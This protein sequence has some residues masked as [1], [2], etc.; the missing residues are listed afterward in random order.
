MWYVVP[1]T[2][3]AAPIIQQWGLPGDVPVPA[4]FSTA[5][6]PTDFAVWRPS[7]GTW[8]ILPNSGLN[9]SVPWGVS[10]DIPVPGDYDG[11]GF[12]D[13]AIWRPSDGNWWIL[14]NVT[15]TPSYSQQFGL[16]GDIPVPGDYDGDKKTDL[17][18][19]RPSEGIWYVLPSSTSVEFT[20]G[21][22]LPGDVPI[23]GDYDS[24]GVT[25]FAVFA[26]SEAN[27]Y[28]LPNNSAPSYYVQQ[29]GVFGNVSIYTQPPPTTLIGAD[30]R[31]TPSNGR[32]KRMPALKPASPPRTLA[33][34]PNRRK[35]LNQ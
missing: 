8:N 23:A 28:V 32:T 9:F 22:G 19:W 35:P 4:V 27:L 31:K 24:D 16:L 7:D 17:A 25:D 21:W 3:P 6:G 5:G 20:K 33:N 10:G 18:V 26:P 2:N 34:V 29:F 15:S 14:P 30:V 11:D 13:F 12:T 1:S